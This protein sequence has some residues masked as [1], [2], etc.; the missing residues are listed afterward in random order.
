LKNTAK[1]EEQKRRINI[2]SREKAFKNAK[3]SLKRSLVDL[4]L[5]PQQRNGLVARVKTI[6][7]I[8][9]IFE[10]GR[11]LSR[12]RFNQ[13]LANAEAKKQ[14]ARTEKERKEAEAEQRRLVKEQENTKIQA[15]KNAMR[16]RNLE[17]KIEDERRKEN[18]KNIGRVKNIKFE[19][20]MRQ[21]NVNRAYLNKYAVGKNINTLN[22]N[23][24]SSKRQSK[25]ENLL[26]WWRT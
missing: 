20:I 3:N 9:D 21:A 18:I 5:T 7:N 1:L 2:Q 25:T 23:T 6:E 12:Q 10:E 8:D 4:K 19:N 22:V 11:T 13:N 15:Q 16:M 14:K 17:R 24:L 26:S